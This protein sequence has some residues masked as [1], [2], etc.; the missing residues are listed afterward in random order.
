MLAVLTLRTIAA[1]EA[2]E[3]SLVVV[4]TDNANP[5]PE[6]VKAWF[7]QWTSGG[8]PGPGIVAIVLSEDAGYSSAHWPDYPYLQVAAT[9][10]GRRLIVYA[11]GRSRD[12]DMVF[13][14]RDAKLVLPQGLAAVEGFS[15]AFELSAAK[16]RHISRSEVVSEGLACVAAQTD[17]P[18]PECET[19]R[20]PAGEAEEYLHPRVSFPAS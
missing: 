2:D 8:H 20:I 16:A 10:C 1:A 12:G 19:K 17:L 4:A 6:N 13:C 15:E 9:R 3:A 14:P 11:T 7:E 5:L 18:L